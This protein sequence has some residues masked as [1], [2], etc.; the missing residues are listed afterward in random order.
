MAKGKICCWDVKEI[1]GVYG[2]QTQMYKAPHHLWQQFRKSTHSNELK[3]VCFVNTLTEHSMDK[4][5]L[6]YTAF[7]SSWEQKSVFGS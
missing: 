1:E 3:L 4:Q 7:H 2:K 6:L 5:S